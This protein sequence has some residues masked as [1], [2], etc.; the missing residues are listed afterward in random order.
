A[1]KGMQNAIPDPGA[2]T[3]DKISENGKTIFFY[4][5]FAANDPESS[6]QIWH[7][8]TDHLNL[9]EKIVILNGR[10]DRYFRSVQLADVCAQIDFDH[11]FLTGERTEKLESYV[12]SLKIP[13]EKVFRIGEI[14]PK[15][16]Y[17]KILE[18]T[19]K[20]AHV[21][22]IGNIAGKNNYGNQIVE[23]FNYKSKGG[24][25]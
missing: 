5:V 16:V 6:K 13:K 25:Q 22:G 23:F 19:K 2:L 7:M 15:T 3:R 17:E 14:S 9:A 20:E 1:L 24:K 4:N 11:L 8:I 10:S 21:V 18:I 12:Y